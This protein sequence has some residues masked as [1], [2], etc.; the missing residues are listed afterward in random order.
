MNKKVIISIIAVILLVA[1]LG[2]VLV[3]CSADSYKKKL[4][5]KG[6]NVSTYT[7]EKDDQDD[8]EWGLLATTGLIGGNTVYIVKYK[9]LDDAKEAESDAKKLAGSVYR[10][11][12]IVMWGTEQG[13]K[14][15]K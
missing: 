8:V 7:V 5:K 3:A 2:T 11:G 15:A 6:Y 13:V 14:D 12:K 10:T 1:V 9:S 4:E